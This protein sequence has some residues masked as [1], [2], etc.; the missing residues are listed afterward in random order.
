[1]SQSTR[2]QFILTT[3][4]SKFLNIFKDLNVQLFLHRYFFHTIQMNVGY[5]ETAFVMPIL[6]QLWRQNLRNSICL[7]RPIW[8]HIINRVLLTFI[9]IEHSIIF[10]S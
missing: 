6:L 9:Y 4:A 1:V 2:Q 7:H 3:D 5:N 8:L 10:S